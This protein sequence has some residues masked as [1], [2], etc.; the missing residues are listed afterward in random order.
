[1]HTQKE[2]II[3]FY[4]KEAA[5]VL[6]FDEIEK[7]T[8]EIDTMFR[9]CEA[10]SIS[11]KK[12]TG[13]NSARF[14]KDWIRQ[15]QPASFL[16]HIL[17]F[18]TELSLC[19]L[20]YALAVCGIRFLSNPSADISTSFADYYALILCTAFLLWKNSKKH[21]VR[22]VLK[23][24]ALLDN[25]DTQKK[26]KHRLF[27]FQTVN[28]LLLGLLCLFLVYFKPAVTTKYH[29]VSG[30]TTIVESFL[31][32]VCSMV[33][34]GIHNTLYQSHFFA[35][36]GVGTA[37]FLRKPKPF[38]TERIENYCRL[39]I[40]QNLQDT[41][42][43]TNAKTTAYAKKTL[44][45]RLTSYRIW[46]FFALFILLLLDILCLT[47]GIKSGLTPAYTTFFLCSLTATALSLTAF[48][49]LI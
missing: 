27:L 26:A 17:C 21:F 8:K 1:M 42:F 47:Q 6:S 9:V 32:Y 44:L 49:L 14:C 36:F 45:P 22:Q 46:L 3:R 34:F 40:S 24:E 19:M 48:F 5:F 43:R 10:L 37:F 33:L 39:S 23:N 35:F 28:G 41:I 38:L 29:F 25:S 15:K 2:D 16:Y 18:V 30:Y 31:G 11:P 4:Q 13:A 20:L 12:C 7:G